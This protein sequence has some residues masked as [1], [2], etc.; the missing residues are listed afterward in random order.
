LLICWF[1]YDVKD[2]GNV[3]N[4]LGIDIKQCSDGFWIGQSSYCKKFLND[5]NMSECK[6]VNTPLENNKLPKSNDTDCLN[7]NMKHTY[8][9]CIGGLLYLSVRTRPD[10]CYAVNYLS[11]FNSAPSEQ[12]WTAVKRVLRYLKG[13]MNFGI[14]YTRN[15]SNVVG[16]SDADF[17]GDINGRRSCSGFVFILSGGAISWGSKKQSSV[18][19]STA[20]SEYVAL[21]L[22][23]QEAV[24]LRRLVSELCDNSVICEPIVIFEDNQ[25]T[26]SISKNYIITNKIKHVDIKLHFIKELIGRKELIVKY[27]PTNLMIADIFT[28][29]LEKIKFVK[30]RKLLG[31]TELT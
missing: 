29:P 14:L 18:A 24:W 10:I 2:L 5:F 25:S 6:P 3:S 26:I 23:S 20:E 15:Q 21:C 1:G 31:I 8:N 30:F 27:C 4:F 19:L 9:S 11:Q 28:K 17:A 7:A 13:T 16:Y 22:A 12:H